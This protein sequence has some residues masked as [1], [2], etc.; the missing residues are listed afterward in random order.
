MPTRTLSFARHFHSEAGGISTHTKPQL[1]EP[2]ISRNSPS[3]HPNRASACYAGRFRIFDNQLQNY[4]YVPYCFPYYT[5]D[6]AD[7]EIQLRIGPSGTVMRFASSGTALDAWN[8]DSEL[9]HR[10]VNGAPGRDLIRRSTGQI[11]YFDGNLRLV[12]RLFADGRRVILA[13]DGARISS[14]NDEVGRS[15]SFGYDSSNR[16]TTMTDPAGGVFRYTYEGNP[17]FPFTACQGEGSSA[18]R[19]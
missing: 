16:M 10:S 18:W 6:A 2:R 12:Q 13:Y 3:F 14:I 11:D 17:V 8:V 9:Q 4:V 1:G 15:L 19:R 5:E 7:G